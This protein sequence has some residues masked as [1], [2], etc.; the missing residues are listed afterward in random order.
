M[1]EI[2][3]NGRAANK[4]FTIDNSDIEYQWHGYCGEVISSKENNIKVGEIRDIG[5][6]LFSAYRI[7]KRWFKKSIVSW[8]TVNKIS[9]ED[10]RE[11]NKQIFS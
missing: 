5:G 2:K 1:S 7:E 10:L 9:I 3:F 8:T 6:I 11:L 4:K